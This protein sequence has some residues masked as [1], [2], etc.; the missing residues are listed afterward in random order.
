MPPQW[1]RPLDTNG[2]RA[3]W[4]SFAGFCVDAMD[5]QLYAFVMPVLIVLWGLSQAEA[6]LLASVTLASSAAGGWVAGLLAD[7]FGRVR[8]LCITILWLAAATVLC[9]MAQ[10]LEHFLAARALQGLGFGA[11][12]A[13][14]AVFISEV[15]SPETRGRVVGAVQ[16]AWAVGWGLAAL[17]STIVLSLLPLEI[18]WRVTFLVGLIPA[19]L[20]FLFRRRIHESETFLTAGRTEPW[21]AIFAGPQLGATLRGSLLAAGMHGGYWAIATWWPQML[22]AERGFS[23]TTT[24]SYFAVIIAGSFFGYGAGA[25][26]SDAAGR[27]ATLAA[28]AMGGLAFV[29]ACTRMA[30]SDLALLLLGFPLGFFALGMFSAIGPVLSELYS[31]GVRGSGLGFCYNLGRGVAALGPALIGANLERTSVSSA[32]GA[33]AAFAY[34]VVLVATALLPETRGRKLNALSV[35]KS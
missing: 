18:G 23:A 6:G 11:E 1:Y 31:T 4:S 17:T 12:W 16:S 33:Y 22:H 25:W 28:F 19:I 20:L 21:H 14:G 24:G 13:V 8:V 10:D 32:V 9:G 26:L 3:F 29:T 30:V 27:R 34:A 7:R 35:Q 15:A 5:V 2:R